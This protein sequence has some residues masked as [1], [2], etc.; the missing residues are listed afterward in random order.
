MLKTFTFPFK[1]F[2]LNSVAAAV[3]NLKEKKTYNFSFN[4]ERGNYMEKAYFKIFQMQWK[5]QFKI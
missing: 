4:H 1:Y 2:L 5:F 3:R